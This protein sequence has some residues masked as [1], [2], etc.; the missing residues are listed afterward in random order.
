MPSIASSDSFAGHCFR[1]GPWEKVAI[2]CMDPKAIHTPLAPQAPLI[3][4]IGESVDG[5]TLIF[6]FAVWY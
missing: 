2:S 5:F 6:S 4:G 3:P 1:F